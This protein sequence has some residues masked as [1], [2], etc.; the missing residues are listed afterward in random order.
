MSLYDRFI[1]P[2]FFR[3][4]P[5]AAHRV[6]LQGLLLAGRIPLGL[7]ALD[8][9]FDHYDPRLETELFGLRFRTPL[10]LAAGYDKDAVAMRE[11][12]ALGF[13]HVEVGTVTVMP[14]A[15]HP[16]PRVF[17]LPE[18]RAI[19]NRMGFPNEGVEKMISR[20]KRARQRD[21]GVPVG[22]NIGKGLHTLLDVAVQ[23]YSHL[24]RQLHPYADFIVVN[25]NFCKFNT[26]CS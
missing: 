14:Q 26:R 21:P 10:G 17:R 5:E 7:R 15:G 24:L 3:L 20:L 18:E 23:D 6:A 19:I 1:R 11:L 22:V 2:L 13:G 12:A 4:D 8:H 25:I 16:R 9:F